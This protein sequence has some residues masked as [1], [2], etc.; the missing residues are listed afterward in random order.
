MKIF[1]CAALLAL[2]PAL[3]FAQRESYKSSS[4]YNSAAARVPD[5][6][7]EKIMAEKFN[8]QRAETPQKPKPKTS[9]QVPMQ[10][11]VETGNRNKRASTDKDKS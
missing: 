9:K 6:E 8:G 10:G 2:L 7:K 5:K 3:S 4:K 1:V 11:P